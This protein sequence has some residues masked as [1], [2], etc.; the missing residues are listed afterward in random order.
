MR[1]WYRTR[2]A[3]WHADREDFALV[4]AGIATRLP[5]ISR[6]IRDLDFPEGHH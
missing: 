5:A 3:A 2:E 1:A 6:R 4:V